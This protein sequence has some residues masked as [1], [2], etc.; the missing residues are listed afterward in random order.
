MDSNYMPHH[1]QDTERLFEIREREK[2]LEEAEQRGYKKGVRDEQK[3]AE[4][5]KRKH[6]KHR[7]EAFWLFVTI[8]FVAYG[9]YT[10]IAGHIKLADDGWFW[11]WLATLGMCIFKACTGDKKLSEDTRGDMSAFQSFFSGIGEFW[12]DIRKNNKLFTLFII[13]WGCLLGGVVGKFN[14]VQRTV[15]ATKKFG[16][17]WISYESKEFEEN[18]DSEVSEEPLQMSES[19][20]EKL[21][22]ELNDSNRSNG[23]S[24]IATFIAKSDYDLD[25]LRRIE[26]SDIELNQ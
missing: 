14:V 22:E 13:C 6:N 8:T 18:D 5:E 15:I 20:G 7:I 10:F 17:A 21:S 9:V 12:K 23:N 26:I 3:R 25:A 11:T 4:K 2:E 16:E 1:E 19:T 24:D